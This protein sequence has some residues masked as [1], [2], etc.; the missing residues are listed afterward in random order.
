MLFRSA[1]ALTL[2]GEDQ[3]DHTPPGERVK[4]LSGIA[5]DLVGERTRV[6]H[7]RVSRNVSEDQIR[8]KLRNAGKK[9][10]M[11]TVVEALYGNWEITVK[12]A[13]FKKQ[14]ADEVQFDLAVPPGQESV[15]T[16]T[17]RYTF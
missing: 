17:V 11:V 9:A 5:F 2:V 12:S 7:T 4:I 15:L 16:Y 10:A 14:N 1:G 13:E 3:I 8:I 6:S